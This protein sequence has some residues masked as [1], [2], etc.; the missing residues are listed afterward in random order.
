V[1]EQ[2]VVAKVGDLMQTLDDVKRYEELAYA[3]IDFAAI[4]ILSVMAVIVLTMVQNFAD[5]AYG[6]PNFINGQ[7][8]L[9]LDQ[10]FPASP[11]I[12]L[13]ELLIL[14][15]GLLLGV[16]W[17]DRR[18]GRTKVGEWKETL[19]EGVP[20]AVKLLSNIEWDSLLGTVSLSRVAY[21]FYALI[22]VAGYFLLATFILSFF[23][24]LLGFLFPVASSL[25]YVPFISLVTVLL[26]TRKSVAEGFRKLRSL[27][28]LF[29][30]LR[31]FS[32]EFKRAE[33]NQA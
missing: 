30:D 6:F 12:L 22:K 13:C 10:S 26:L 31:W 7:A 28:L 32:S 27:D 29:W 11:W 33:F 23:F 17:V 4:I 20:G 9:L 5:I 25:N 21:L 8:Y 15:G 14:V 1:S 24:L 19:N 3:M 2:D 16:V 18:V